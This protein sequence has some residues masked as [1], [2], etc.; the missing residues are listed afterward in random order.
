MAR[1]D[2]ACRGRRKYKSV[3]GRT[4]RKASDKLTK[5]L[6]EVQQG[7][8]LPDERRRSRSS[9]KPGSSR[10]VPDFGRVPG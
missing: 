1:V 10:N 9:L 3:Y 8:A 7:V 5:L 6:R 4:R 2:S